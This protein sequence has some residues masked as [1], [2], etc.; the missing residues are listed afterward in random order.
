LVQQ[1]R[2]LG[3]GFE[4]LH[5]KLLFFTVPYVVSIRHHILKVVHG[6]E[7]SG[8]AVKS[9]DVEFIASDVDEWNLV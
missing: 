5:A 6:A 7:E 9:R 1:G 4:Q 3:Q 8:S 2:K